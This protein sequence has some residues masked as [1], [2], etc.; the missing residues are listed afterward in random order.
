MI[1]LIQFPWSPFCIV[2]RRIL[3]FSGVRFKITNIPNQRPLPGLEADQ[4]AL[5]RRARSSGTA[6]TWCSKSATIPRSSPSISTQKLELGLFPARTGGR[7]IHPLALHR[8]RNRG[9]GV[10]AQR[11]LL[12][13]NRAARPT[14]CRFCGTR[15]A[16][17]AA[18]AWT[19]GASSRGDWLQQ[20]E[21]RLLPFE[22][23]LTHQPFLLGDRPRFVDFDLYG[24]LE[25]FL[26]SGHYQLPRR[27]A[28]QD[29]H[30]RMA[31]LKLKVKM[32]AGLH[33]TSRS[34][35]FISII[36]NSREKLHPRH[37]RPPPR[38]QLAAQ[39][40]G[41]Q[42]PDPHRSHRGNRPVQARVHR[43][44]PERPHGVADARRLSRRGQPE[45]RREAAQRRQAA[46]RLSRRTATRTATAHFNGNTVDNRIL[47]ARRRASRR[48]S[49]KTR[50]SSS[51]RTSTCASRPT[52]SGCRP[53]ITRPT[54]CSSRTSTP[55]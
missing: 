6:G 40:R 15:N 42:R 21:Q 31:R 1:E 5:L 45:R 37:Q 35:R 29:W 13:G 25:N 53:R 55:A 47:V 32:N 43:A 7:A 39:L 24:M 19:N 36:L 10:P 8:K 11:H 54:A 41:Q 20:L 3:E 2:Q 46:N 48:R 33:A 34:A 17:S 18:A 38:P 30:R 23:M 28:A 26:Y 27:T 44:G 12:A 9:R 49:R 52:R 51:A 16:S 14:S 50:P 4:A 22:E